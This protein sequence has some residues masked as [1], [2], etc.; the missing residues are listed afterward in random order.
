[1]IKAP[2]FRPLLSLLAFALVSGCVQVEQTLS[3]Q[4]DGSG[5]LTVQY[6]VPHDTVAK[7]EAQL[8][9]QAGSGD[10]PIENPFSFDTE[11]IR[12]DFK[13]YEPLGI[14]LNDA[15]SWE[16]GGNKRIRL[17]IHFATLAG[18]MKTEFFSD[19]N[20]QLKR[21]PDGDYE[22]RQKGSP[23]ERSDPEMQELMRAA[24][25][26]FR[27]TLTLETPGDVV[28]SN[29]DQ[30]ALRRV[31]WLFDVDADSNALVRAQEMDLWVRFSSTGLTL[32]EYPASE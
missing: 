24:M 2:L 6:S 15:R 25:A 18:V 21:L 9:A 5:T 10:E 26:G 22:F 12:A 8:R 14:T 31:V 7:M 1:M 32:P 13:E 3:L 16:E 29:A 23:E 17:E 20:V 4:G 30:R 11:K 27:G 19:R 28:D